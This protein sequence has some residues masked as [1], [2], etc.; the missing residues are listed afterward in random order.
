MFNFVAIG[1]AISETAYLPPEVESMS[2]EQVIFAINDYYQMQHRNGDAG[3]IS[4]EKVED[5]HVVLYVR[6]PYPDDLEYGTAFGFARRFL[7]PNTHFIVQYDKDAVR[8]DQGGEETI[9]HVT[10][11]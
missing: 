3:Q 4:V 2:F 7:P 5:K 11:E 9:I 8:H 1:A 6:V 10:W